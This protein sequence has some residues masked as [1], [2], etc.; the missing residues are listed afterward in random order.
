LLFE[1]LKE[2]DVITSKRSRQQDGR[3]GYPV[4]IIEQIIN[5]NEI[6]VT[7]SREKKKRMI[8]EKDLQAMCLIESALLYKDGLLRKA[9][10]EF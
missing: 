3:W 7:D 2:G 5:S 8:D 6:L 9:R 4:Y 1:R 10:I